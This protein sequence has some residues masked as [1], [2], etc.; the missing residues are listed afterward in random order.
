M[1]RRNTLGTALAVLAVVLFTVPAFFP[2]QSVLV[3]ETWDSATGPPEELR[4]EGHEII[5][6][7]NL[8]ERG[9]ELYVTTLE[10]DGEYSVPLGEGASEFDYLN[11]SE[12]RR[13][14]ETDNRS[15]VRSVV[16]ERPEDDDHLP[17]A[18]EPNFGPRP[19]EN[20]SEGERQRAEVIQRYDAMDTATEEPP[21]GST[22]QL[23]RLAS[24]LLAVL[25]LGVGGYLLSSK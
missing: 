9:Q 25:S 20:A 23:I 8:S 10:N 11:A 17:E 3:H 13:A 2:V 24:V 12:R 19:G 14:Y 1:N 4:E 18:D 15:A 21:L 6:Y 5:A 7:E 16:I 22:P